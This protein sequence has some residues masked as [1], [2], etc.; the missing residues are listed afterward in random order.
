MREPPSKVLA[1][2]IAEYPPARSNKSSTPLEQSPRR[3]AAP[4]N[5]RDQAVAN[6]AS[7]SLDFPAIVARFETPLLRYVGKMFGPQTDQ[8]EDI[9]Q[10]A[11]LRLIQRQ[12]DDGH[13]SIQNLNA[14]LFRVTHNL[15]MDALRKKSRQAIQDAAD[16]DT[17][18]SQDTDSLG[19]LE[20]K[21][22]CQRAV[23]ELHRLP[24]EQK[25]ALLLR[26]M[27]GMKFREISETTETSIANVAYR[28]NSGLKELTRR[29]K[30]QGVI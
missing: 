17:S 24:D 20:H 14:W 11:F 8:A 26:I 2:E 6:S 27:H 25:E 21:E 16:P 30:G 28:V 4:A 13:E 18:R 3:G 29:L 7:Q 9:V 23:A 15:T 19:E 12:R 5:D 10:E 1:G 22:L